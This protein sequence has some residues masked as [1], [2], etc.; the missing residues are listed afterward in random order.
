MTKSKLAHAVLT[1]S[2]RA[3]A[4]A[5]IDDLYRSVQT[6]IDLR[7]PV[8]VV[9]G[10]CCRFDQFGHRLY[11]T[12][13]ELAHFLHHL[14]PAH[15][16][17]DNPGGCPF[18]VQKLCTTHAFRPFGCRIFFCDSTSTEWQNRMYERFHADLKRLHETLD[19]PYFY[20]EWREALAML[21]RSELTR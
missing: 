8:C 11:V 19:V 5:S 10:R 7:R 18:Q 20:I 16:R 14:P 1:A 6:Q 2:R 17:I 21:P 13:L 3:E 12:T 4:L 15:P 9:S